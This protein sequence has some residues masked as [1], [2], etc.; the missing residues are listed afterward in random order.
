MPLFF[1]LSSNLFFHFGDVDQDRRVILAGQRGGILQA[2]FASRCKSSAAPAAA[3]ISG[4]PC[5][6]CRNFSV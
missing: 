2:F 6:F 1:R 3:W 4:S 5:H